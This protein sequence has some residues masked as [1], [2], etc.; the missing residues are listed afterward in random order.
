MKNH[1]AAKVCIVGLGP[2]GIGAALMLSRLGKKIDLVCIDGGNPPQKRYCSKDSNRACD[3]ESFCQIIC[4]FGGCALL[5]GG[6]ISEFPAGDGLVSVYGSEDNTKKALLQALE[7]MSAYLTLEKTIINQVDADKEK[8]LFNAMGFEYRYYDAYLCEQKGLQRAFENIFQDLELSGASLLMRS[9]LR[10]VKRKDDGFDLTVK[11]AATEVNIH[12]DYLLLAVG[13]SGRAMLRDLNTKMG[14]HGEENSLDIGVRLEFPNRLFDEKVKI[15]KD[16]KLVFGSARTFC[17]CRDGKI[18]H[19]YSNSLHFTEGCCTA[20]EKSG[21]TNLGI[22]IRLP[23]SK[24]NQLVFNNMR[25]KMIKLHDGKIISQNL[26]DYLLT[27]DYKK[28]NPHSESSNFLEEGD[29]NLCFPKPI[30]SS[31]RDAVSYFAIRFFPQENWDKVRVFAPEVDYGGLR[32]PL[33]AEFSIIPNMYL[34]GDCTGRFRGILQAF[35]SG[36]SCAKN[37]KGDL[38]EKNGQK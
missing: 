28:E 35:S 9:E 32:F 27:N 7:I 26:K 10:D 18:V 37:I 30:S 12:T 6:K 21:L 31:V 15:H 13:R 1:Q 36:I 29:I 2:A 19:Y 24:N 34:I 5:S 4:G 17:V 11:N 23:A 8:S 33:S 22:T 16:L 3:K 14:L 25:K 20:S 38:L